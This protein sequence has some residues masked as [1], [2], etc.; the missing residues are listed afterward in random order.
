VLHFVAFRRH[1]LQSPFFALGPVFSPF[2]FAASCFIDDFPSFF[3]HRAHLNA[4]M[5]RFQVSY[6]LKVIPEVQEYLNA[7][8][9]NAKKRGG[10][11]DDLY[12][13]R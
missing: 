5:Q 3:H 9:E 1:R 11:L 10:D 12:R 4:D 13:R 8:F 7:A 6:N 2:F